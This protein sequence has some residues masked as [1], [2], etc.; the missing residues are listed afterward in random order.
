MKKIIGLLIGTVLTLNILVFSMST[1][2]DYN[3]GVFNAKPVTADNVKL[4][5]KKPAVSAMAAIVV[6]ME[7][8]RVLYEKNAYSKRAIASTT[9]IMTAIVALENGN[10]ED[11]VTVSKRA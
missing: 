1:A 7:S 10:L 4:R 6:D 8:G 3:E 5:S 2:D 11:V 9:K